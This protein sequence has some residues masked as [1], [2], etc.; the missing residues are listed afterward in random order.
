M[1]GSP[2][3]S[4]EDDADTA[5]PLRVAAPAARAPRGETTGAP[6]WHIDAAALAVLENV[7]SM[8]HFPNVETRKKLGDDLNVSA[9]QIQVWFQNRRQ[10]ER[11]RKEKHGSG[12]V[13]KDAGLLSTSGM[14][15]PAA[16]SEDVG[17]ALMAADDADCDD[18][19]DQSPA[20]RSK[21]N[22]PLAPM[23]MIDQTDESLQGVSAPLSPSARNYS[24][25]TLSSSATLIAPSSPPGNRLAVPNARS[26]AETPPPEPAAAATQPAMAPTAEAEAATAEAAADAPV[27]SA[28][29]AAP[30]SAQEASAL[31]APPAPT[32]PA[33]PPPLPPL[34]AP[35]LAKRGEYNCLEAMRALLPHALPAASER[36]LGSGGTEALGRMC[37]EAALT[38]RAMPSVAA[39]LA[40]ACQS[41]L[42]GKTLQ[43]F[44]GVVQ[45]ITEATPPYRIL[46][47]SN[48]WQRLC[49]YHR[50]EVLG[51]SMYFL[52]G[53]RTEIAA[54][55]ALMSAVSRDE[56]V[57]VRLT[58]YTKKGLP[59]SHYLSIE[60]LRD[61]S[62]VTK[63]FQATSLV[64]QAPGEPPCDVRCAAPP[65]TR[66]RPPLL[67]SLL[68]SPCCPC[69]LP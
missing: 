55:A 21:S 8:D 66:R 63:C 62:D 26:Q 15:T 59:F 57:A 54:V 52:Q 7:F 40:A 25:M 67:C 35:P 53:P 30:G 20:K 24:S 69:P 9:R 42:L 17:A 5:C 10:R 33:A 11:K 2:D 32:A 61:P 68:R 64:L 1:P 19:D 56:S 22:L 13:H 49:G 43:N 65:P 12:T 60:P 51:H 37:A 6:R 44:G 16:S 58:N 14:T 29:E 31:P 4:A 38:E 48:G 27:P 34:G 50:E 23:P 36:E 28:A 3:R 47:V 18:A 39:R 41:T 45:A 46:S